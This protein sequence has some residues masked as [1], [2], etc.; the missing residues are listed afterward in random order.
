MNSFV[1]KISAYRFLDAVKPIG[2]LFVL[3]FAE[4][5][6]TPFQISVLIC[7]WSATQ[8]LLEVPLGAVADKFPRRNLLIIAL[9]IHAIGFGFWLLGGFLFFAI[10]FILWGIKGAL[11]SGTL[12][13]LVYDELKS[14][15][16]ETEYEK[17]NGRLESV[18]WTGITASVLFGGLLSMYGYTSAVVV[19]IVTTLLAIVPLLLVARAPI[20]RST[21]EVQYFQI[22]KKALHEVKSNSSL[23]YLILFFCLIFAPYSAADEYW[24]LVY[25]ELGLS[26]I[27]LSMI[28]AVG[29][30]MFIVAGAT[31][32]LFPKFLSRSRLILA[33]ALV[34]ILTTVLNSDLTIPLILLAMYVLK[35]AH[36]KFEASFQHAIDSGN[37]ATVTSLKSL[38]FEIGY[39]GFVLI[40]GFAGQ[41]F[42]IIT[43][44]WVMGATIIAGLLLAQ[45]IKR[46]FYLKNS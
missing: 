7:I 37:R 45:I 33:G 29:Y 11:T 14:A 6:I 30:L 15:G 38:L 16:K 39:L 21:K 32:Y 10:G 40:F 41:I 12:E 20:V 17:V 28:L 22:L 46:L 44:V 27:L 26:G 36:V 42:G 19:S 5:G 3:L 18:F 9:L 43:V 23:L 24:P 35:V 13:A 34:L 31:S 4:Q 25:S 1:I 2:V 8:M